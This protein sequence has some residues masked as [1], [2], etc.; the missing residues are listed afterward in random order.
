M[1]NWLIC[2]VL[3]KRLWV[4]RVSVLLLRV[5]RSVCICSFQLGTGTGRSR[6]WW[7]RRG[8]WSADAKVLYA[9]IAGIFFM[10]QSFSALAFCFVV[11][12]NCCCCY[13][14]SVDCKHLH[15]LRLF[16]SVALD[17]GL[18]PSAPFQIFALCLALTAHENENSQ[19]WSRIF[20]CVREIN[21]FLW[22]SAKLL[23][24]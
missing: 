17:E 8:I 7:R 9:N 14:L 20:R 24:I 10:S 16:C 3:P 2:F 19:A 11:P 4:E 18:P 15:N 5:C 22:S 6:R 1:P 13:C 12:P 21:I 23:R